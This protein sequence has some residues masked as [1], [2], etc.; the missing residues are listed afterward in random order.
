VQSILFALLVFA[1]IEKRLLFELAKLTSVVSSLK[2]EVK[3]MRAEMKGALSGPVIQN[4]GITVPELDNGPIK[5]C[6]SLKTFLERC[7][8]KD[9][10]VFL[11]RAESILKSQIYL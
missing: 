1:G 6:Q 7:N 3:E 2:S 10:Q 11:V 4:S 5:T 8:A 9:V